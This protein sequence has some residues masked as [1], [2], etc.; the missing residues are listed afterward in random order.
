[1]A[2]WADW[3]E[4][5]YIVNLVVL[6]DCMYW[7]NMVHVDKFSTHRTIELLKVKR[8][9]FANVTMSFYALRSSNRA[10]LVL[11]NRNLSFYTLED[12]WG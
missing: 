7:Y 5:I 4:I 2:I 1:M 6:A 9:N 8:T 11:V 12:F 3:N 10:A